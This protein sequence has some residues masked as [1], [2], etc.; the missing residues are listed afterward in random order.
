MESSMDSKRAGRNRQVTERDKDLCGFLAACRYLTREQVERLMFPGRVK[1]R[2]STRLRQLAARVG[3]QEAVLRDDVGFGRPDGWTTVWALTAEGFRIGAERAELEVA[4][5]PKK[6][7]S[8][9]FLKHE[10]E[11]NELYLA[12][13]PQDGQTP[14]TLPTGFRWL[15]G[16]YLDLPFEKFKWGEGK[17]PRR[18]EPDAMIEVPAARRRFFVEY[19]TGTATLDDPKKNTSTKGKL[20]RYRDFIRTW[21]GDWHGGERRTRYT[22]AFKDGWPPELL[23]VAASRARRDSINRLVADWSQLAQ[24]GFKI[25]ALTMGEAQAELFA[26][27]HGRALGA[28]VAVPGPARAAA[29]VQPPPAPALCPGVA[30]P[31]AGE[32]EERLR[33][34]RVAVRG[35]WLPRIDEVLKLMIGELSGAKSTMPLPQIVEEAIRCQAATEIYAERAREA[36]EA[37]GIAKAR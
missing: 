16:A 26:L 1:A 33:P 15:Q 17:V 6:D 3:E 24:P 32:A 22:D 21:V 18:L 34:G 30:P 8:Q 9:Q 29:A 5:K 27:V 10:V 37:Y 28:P 23:F 31:A 4:R 7:L 25:R 36:L 19:E 14:A 13:V 11:L 2:S 12:V 35:E 20:A